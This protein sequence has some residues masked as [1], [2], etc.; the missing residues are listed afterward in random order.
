MLHF[1]LTSKHDLTALAQ[2]WPLMC[3]TSLACDPHLLTAC[4]TD[5]WRQ[6]GKP[7]SDFAQAAGKD[8]RLIW[9]PVYHIPHRDLAAPSRFVRV[10]TANGTALTLSSEHIVYVSDTASGPRKPL[11]ARDVKVRH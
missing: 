9:S 8:G 4:S 7:D 11:A 1:E 5:L 10:S 6:W 2:A 3:Q